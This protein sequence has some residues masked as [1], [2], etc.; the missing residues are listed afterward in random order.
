MNKGG[1]QRIEVV[2][3]RSAAGNEPVREWLIDLPEGHRRA[4]GQ[5]L[6][7]VQYC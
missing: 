5:D 2:F 7:R 6:Q 3:Y 4:V 1:T